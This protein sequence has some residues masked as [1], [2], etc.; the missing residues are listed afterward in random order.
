MVRQPFATSLSRSVPSWW[1]TPATTLC[2]FK[3]SHSSAAFA[4]HRL[5]IGRRDH[6][7]CFCTR[8]AGGFYVSPP[9]SQPAAPTHHH[10]F[11]LSPLRST[12]RP[13][14]YPTPDSP[15]RRFY[16]GRINSVACWVHS[17]CDSISSSPSTTRAGVACPLSRRRPSLRPFQ[18]STRR[19]W[20]P[21]G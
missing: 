13:W 15:S 4:L 12:C 3:E 18:V 20:D 5:S 7:G 11:G 21:L 2:C 17:P 8:V 19:V 6:I 16:R 14:S 1:S 10:N 9:P